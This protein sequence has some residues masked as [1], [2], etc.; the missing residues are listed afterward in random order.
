[1]IDD[2]GRY[3][4]KSDEKKKKA[5]GNVQKT[6]IFGKGE[7]YEIRALYDRLNSLQAFRGVT[8]HKFLRMLIQSGVKEYKRTLKVTTKPERSIERV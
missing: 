4:T 5:R 2:E 6:I 7:F 3:F 8:F 1:M